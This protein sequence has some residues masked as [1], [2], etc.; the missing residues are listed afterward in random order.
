MPRTIAIH[1]FGGTSLGD[2]SRIRNAAHLLAAARRRR[3]VVAVAS[4]MGGVTDVL[5]EAAR[6]AETAPLG[7]ARGLE[8]DVRHAPHGGGDGHDGSPP[9]GGGEEMGG[10]PDAGR[11]AQGGPAEFVDGD[12]ARGSR[13]AS[14]W[15]SRRPWR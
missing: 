8:K 14:G 10:I 11:V 2:A 13:H 6:D 5:L 9:S 1:K 15:Y 4:A 7:V 12:R 3:P